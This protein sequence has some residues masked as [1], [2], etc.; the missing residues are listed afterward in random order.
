MAIRYKTLDLEDRVVGEFW[1]EKEAIDL[2]LEFYPN[3]DRNTI[4]IFIGKEEIRFERCF[5]SYYD[6]W[7]T[8]AKWR[9]G[10]KQRKIAQ[11]IAEYKQWV[12]YAEL[13]DA[14]R[15][16]FRVVYKNRGEKH[17]RW[18]MTGVVQ[19]GSMEIPIMEVQPSEIAGH[20]AAPNRVHRVTP[21]DRYEPPSR[22]RLRRVIKEEV[23]RLK[24]PPPSPPAP[25]PR[26]A[27]KE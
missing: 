2:F 15:H 16:T 10:R 25:P 5:D 24:D 27:I 11:A 21:E 26:H 8:Y 19:V 13:V 1:T 23:R 3:F 18:K 12:P 22:K 4:H 9:L 20:F 7:L 17:R 6:G 14:I